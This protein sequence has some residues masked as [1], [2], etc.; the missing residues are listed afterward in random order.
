MAT[1]TL[2]DVSANATNMKPAAQVTE[3]TTISPTLATGAGRQ[4][5][6]KKPNIFTHYDIYAS[7][8]QSMLYYVDISNFT[9][10]KPDLTL[11]AGSDQHGPIAAVSHMP[12]T[13]GNYKIGLG[14]PSSPNAI[15]E[16]MEK[17]S[18]KANNYQMAFALEDGQRWPLA[19]KRTHEHAV[20]NKENAKLSMRDWKLVDLQ[21]GQIV[22]LF[23]NERW[24]VTTTGTV[25]INGDYGRGFD[26]LVFI[27][28]LSLYEKIRRRHQRGAM[29]ANGAG[30]GS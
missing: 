15:W 1:H 5:R 3:T 24:S 13:T 25:Q 7:G 26:E 21:T 2:V 30:G 16:T 20:D 6:I 17:M 29:Y 23:T 19:W 28:V 14:D 27:T 10:N 8:S 12:I 18:V 9:R 4:F 11:H 22:A